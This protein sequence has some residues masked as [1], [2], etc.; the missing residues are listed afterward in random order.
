MF[1]YWIP[2]AWS[3]GKCQIRVSFVF[4]IHSWKGGGKVILKDG[5][6][7][8]GFVFSTHPNLNLTVLMKNVT[9]MSNFPQF[10]KG[11]TSQTH[12]LE[13]PLARGISPHSTIFSPVAA[14]RSGL[15]CGGSLK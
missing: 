15:R 5:L 2:P 4:L 8:C 3:G 9:S 12:D 10:G 11:L 6:C 14:P 1:G 13:E 7:P